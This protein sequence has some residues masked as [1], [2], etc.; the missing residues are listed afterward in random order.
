MR[1]SVHFSTL[2]S[3]SAAL[4]ALAAAVFVC[5]LLLA[6]Q[7]AAEPLDVGDRIAT[8]TLE[9]QH[10]ASH[11]FDENVHILLF[12]RDMEGGKLLK[13]ALAETPAGFLDERHAIYVSDISGMPGLVARM[14]AIPRMRDRAYPMWLDRDGE[15]TARL[16]DEEGKATLVF[17]R[18]RAIT[19]IEH[20]AT[21]EEVRALLEPSVP[22][23]TGDE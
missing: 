9:D 22:P 16:P 5:F 10:G 3:R 7:A 15:A 6:G 12:S 1:A 18:D 14:I 17:C 20:L 23:A 4:T 11:T 19:R 8:F 21:A 2:L 13:E